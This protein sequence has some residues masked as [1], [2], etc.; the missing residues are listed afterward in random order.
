MASAALMTIGVVKKTLIDTISEC[1]DFCVT[2]ADPKISDFPLMA[3]SDKFEQMTGYN[4]SEILGKNCRF[5]NVNC[6]VDEQ[7]RV[8]LRKACATGEPFSAVL[9]NSKKSGELFMNMLDL[10]GLT[11]ARNGDAE[12]WFLIGIQADISKLSED[13]E[14]IT[15]VRLKDIRKV[16]DMIRLALT[17]ELALTASTSIS[18]ST[19]ESWTVLPKPEWK[20]EH[21]T[22]TEDSLPKL[23]TDDGAFPDASELSSANALLV[24]ATIEVAPKER[25]DDPGYVSNMDAHWLCVGLGLGCFLLVGSLTLRNFLR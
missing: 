12:L 21:R 9:L 1:K 13:E 16:V 6:N 4:R 15:E 8:A 5:L 2:I 23:R 17:K 24:G 20:G 7:R 18:V 25:E 3:V 10:R 19:A 22:Y 11:V 14:E